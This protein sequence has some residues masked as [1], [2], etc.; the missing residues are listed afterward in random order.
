[1]TARLAQHLLYTWWIDVQRGRKPQRILG[2]VNT[3][4]AMSEGLWQHFPATLCV[5]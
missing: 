5:D 4:T 1:M 3:F 2:T